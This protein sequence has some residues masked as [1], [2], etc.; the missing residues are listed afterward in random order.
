MQLHPKTLNSLA[1]RIR[2][3]RLLQDLSREQ[4]AAVCDVSASFIRDAEKDPGSCSVEKLLRLVYGLGLK[5]RIEGWQND[6]KS[7]VETNKAQGSDQS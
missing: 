6:I 7:D 3:E 2:H 4:L 5:V 1:L